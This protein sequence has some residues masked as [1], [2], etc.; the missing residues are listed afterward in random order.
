MAIEKYLLMMLLIALSACGGN[1]SRQ[2]ETTY[3]IDGRDGVRYTVRGAK[4]MTKDEIKA[5]VLAR[6]PNASNGSGSLTGQ[7]AFIDLFDTEP[8]RSFACVQEL[9]SFH[10]TEI[11]YFVSRYRANRG[12]NPSIDEVLL[13]ANASASS[14]KNFYPWRYCSGYRDIYANDVYSIAGEC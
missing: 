5:A 7:T 1:G 11:C 3:S 2:G 6:H 9:R 10:K 13:R 8:R 4:G 14:A 12:R